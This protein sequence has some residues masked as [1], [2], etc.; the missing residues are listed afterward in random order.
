[1][2]I[3]RKEIEANITIW[4]TIIILALTPTFVEWANQS[5]YRYSIGGEAML[6]LVP[7]I[8]Y[9]MLDTTREMNKARRSEEYAEKDS[10]EI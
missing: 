1:M 7:Y 10:Y 4:A 2:K 5:R 9:T 3:K 8:I 6:W